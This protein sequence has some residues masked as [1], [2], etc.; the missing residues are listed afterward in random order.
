MY[1]IVGYY[2]VA[3]SYEKN[4][5]NFFHIMYFENNSTYYNYTEIS[6]KILSELKINAL[7][8]LGTIFSNYLWGIL[9]LL[10]VINLM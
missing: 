6:T 1:E 2:K 3:N 4:A 7:L 8:L 9:E 10:K 5:G